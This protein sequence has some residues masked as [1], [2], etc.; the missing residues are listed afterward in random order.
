MILSISDQA[1][2]LERGQVALLE[3]AETL[4]KQPALLEQLLGVQ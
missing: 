2:V 1:L 4:L 3:R